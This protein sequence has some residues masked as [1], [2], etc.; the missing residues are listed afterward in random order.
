MTTPRAGGVL[1]PRK[2]RSLAH[3]VERAAPGEVYALTV[4]GGVRMA[5]MEGQQVRFGRNRPD[6]DVCVGEDDVQVSRRHGVLTRRFGQWWVGN[7]GR[8]PIRFPGA[9]L[10][11]GG[12]DEVPLEEGYTPLFIRGA[13]NREHL[14]EVY[15]AGSD[16][17]RPQPRHGEQTRPPRTWVLR[18]EEK[19]MLVVLGQRYL[20]HDARP[21]PMSRQHTAEVL[22]GLQPGAGW[23]IKRVEHMVTEVRA[24]LSAGGVAGL[25]KAEVGEPVGNALN[26]NLLR[27]LVLSTTLVPPDLGLLDDPFPVE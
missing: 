16:G 26:D 24:R 10:L 22:A 4:T 15:V 23:T 18:P 6:V 13:R 14:L 9:L 2:H 5:P 8:L 21:Q 3:G 20:L 7:T 12:E 17:G 19:L 11:C 1:L 27:E 25:T